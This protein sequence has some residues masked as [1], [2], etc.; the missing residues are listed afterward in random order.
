MKQKIKIWDVPTR[1]FHWLLVAAIAFMW[2][3]AKTGGSLL[4]WHLRCGLLIL[5]LLIFR[6]CWGLWG[7]DSA[8]FTQFVRGPKQIL[9]YLK[10]EQPEPAGHNPLGSLMVV[11][12][13]LA[14][15]FQVLT[16]LFSPDS[17]TFIYNGYLNAW[18]DSATGDKLHTL[19]LAFFNGLLALIAV[20]IAA[21]LVY[22]FLKKHDLIRPMIT[23]W[24]EWS[25]N[26]PP[27]KFAGAGKLAAALLIAA[28]MVWAVANIA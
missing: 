21:I 4:A 3:S 2:F 17:N 19:H 7:S 16:G 20:H 25:G 11:A 12:L 1:L 22:K 6:L 14:V 10:G 23:G 27:L 8:R 15:A 13:L 5:G 18:V 24:R 26:V 9:R 28:A